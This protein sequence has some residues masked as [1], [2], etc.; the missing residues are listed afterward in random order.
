MNDRMSA[1]LRT[2]IRETFPDL[3]YL[4]TYEYRIDS[5]DGNTYDLAPTD[6]KI[7]LPPLP[8]VKVK[9][10]IPGLTSGMVVDALVYVRFINADRT[11][12][13][14]DAVAGPGDDGFTPTSLTLDVSSSGFVN[15]AVGATG[16]AINLAA[17]AGS[18]IREGDTVQIGTGVAASNG[19]V[20]V[21]TITAGIGIPPA[22]SRVKA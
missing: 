9:P 18:V 6:K 22:P 13:Y 15:I 20:G 7:G 17:A 8:A 16:P 10:G 11:R 2:I 19:A 3:A 21:V 14:I 4:G 5:V 1:A 12:P